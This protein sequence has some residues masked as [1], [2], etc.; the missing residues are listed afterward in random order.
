MK[1]KQLVHAAASSGHHD[2]FFT[3]ITVV[4][5]CSMTSLNH[6]KRLLNSRISHL[7]GQL[8]MLTNRARETDE[9]GFGPW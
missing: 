5:S 3:V 1:M 9:S 4:W 6:R 8:K 7:I 2:H